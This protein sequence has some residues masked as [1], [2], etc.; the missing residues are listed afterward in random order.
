MKALST[1]DIHIYRLSDKKHAFNFV[2]N[3]AFFHSFPESLVQRAQVNV[4][5]VLE[6]SATMLAL[7]FSMQGTIE[8]TCDRSLENFDFVLKTQNRLILKLGEENQVLT[9]EIEVIHRDTQ[10]INVAQYIYEFILLQ[11]PMKKLHPKFE[12]GGN[13][14][15]DLLI[16]TSAKEDDTK[17]EPDPRW[18][19]L[20]KLKTEE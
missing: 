18:E 9:D 1:F 16:Y 19:I 7:Q 20:K 2:V 8:L 15:G 6:K 10:T 3:D 13:N 12:N 14:E 11:V 17:Q 4:D 5:L